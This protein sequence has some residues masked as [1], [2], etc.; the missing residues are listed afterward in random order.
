[1][2][3]EASYFRHPAFNFVLFYEAGK[4]SG[5]VCIFMGT[6]LPLDSVYTALGRRKFK[7]G[8]FHSENASN[9]FRPNYA[10]GLRKLINQ[11]STWTRDS[12]NYRN[13][14]FSENPRFKNVF[15]PY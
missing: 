1:M 11:R 2:K 12:H 7:K 5:K 10:G 9:V 6:N 13:V 8:R 15:R 4:R 14:V 3:I